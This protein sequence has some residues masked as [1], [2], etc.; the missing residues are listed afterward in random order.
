[1]SDK[2]E[3]IILDVDTYA[4]MDE[5]AKSFVDAFALSHGVRPWDCFRVVLGHGQAWFWTY[6]RHPMHGGRYFENPDAPMEERVVA[7][8]V[9]RVDVP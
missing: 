1:M 6:L 9:Y 5:V 3:I 7:Y 8:R 4:S 2:P